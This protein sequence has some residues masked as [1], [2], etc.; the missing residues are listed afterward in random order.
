MEQISIDFTTLQQYLTIK[1]EKGKRYIFCT[2]RHKYL[3]ITPEE[4]V[5]Q[6]LL[7]Y[8]IKIK[9]YPKNRIAVEKQLTING[10]KKR[11]DILV[12]NKE[13]EPEILIECK[14]P[15]V[16]ITQAVFNQIAQ[17]NM[18]L[19]SD[20]LIVSN[21]KS[22]YCCHVDRKNQQFE[23]LSVIPVFEKNN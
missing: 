15:N 2:I 13:V 12:L 23:F 11:F 5:R 18:S 22:T 17:Y 8:L 16:P 10:R 14:A 1:N 9:L 7:L 20:L 21:G 19:N 3:V 4:I 6:L